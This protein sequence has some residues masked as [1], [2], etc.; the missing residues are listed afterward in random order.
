MY[1]DL[2]NRSESFKQSRLKIF[3]F[4]KTVGNKQPAVFVLGTFI[5]NMCCFKSHTN[6]FRGA[7][8]SG[9][10]TQEE[11]TIEFQIA[12]SDY[13]SVG[14]NK[15]NNRSRSCTV[16]NALKWR[17]PRPESEFLYFRSVPKNKSTPGAPK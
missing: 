3:V 6:A 12:H 17:I 15:H 13:N 10:A 8:I 14:R 7:F 16:I 5:N 4:C 11:I 9:I 2:N 1:I